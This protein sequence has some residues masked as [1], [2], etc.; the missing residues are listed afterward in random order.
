MVVIRLSLKY[1]PKNNKHY[2]VLVADQRYAPKGRYI[3][4]VGSYNPIN[5]TAELNLERI[6]YWVSQGAQ[7][8][9]SVK[10]IVKQFKKQEASAV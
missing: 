6:D 7:V 8:S 3:E 10:K 2:Q 5:Q 4:R 1:R 9:D